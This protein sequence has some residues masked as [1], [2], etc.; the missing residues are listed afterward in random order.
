MSHNF[1]IMLYDTK[2]DG[3]NNNFINI[4]KD[5]TLIIQNLTLL[6]NDTIDSINTKQ[7]AFEVDNNFNKII[8]SYHNNGFYAYENYYELYKDHNMVYVSD[9]G[10]QPPLSVTINIENNEISKCMI[11]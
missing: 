5:D 7:Y 9:I 3:W 1:S 11:F 4:Y 2:Q 8:I 6:Y 10:E